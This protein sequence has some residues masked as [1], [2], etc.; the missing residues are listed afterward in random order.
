[1]LYLQAVSQS[2]QQLDTDYV[3]LML[4]HS[5]GSDPA[6]RMQAWQALEKAHKEASQGNPVYI[7]MC[8]EYT[9]IILPV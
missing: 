3:D 7:H 6:K 8:V 1:M 4:L 9:C 2:L 5:P